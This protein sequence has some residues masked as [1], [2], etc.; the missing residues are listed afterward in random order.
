MLTLY[1]KFRF[2]GTKKQYEAAFS[3]LDIVNLTAFFGKFYKYFKNN[4]FKH[5]LPW[6]K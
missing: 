3:Y 1:M 4:D 6:V 5:T 2:S